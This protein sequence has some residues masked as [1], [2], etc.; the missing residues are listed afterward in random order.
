MN[1]KR[2]LVLLLTAM[3]LF[4]MGACSKSGSGKSDPVMDKAR[5]AWRAAMGSTQPNTTTAMSHIRFTS[6]FELGRA[7][8]IDTARTSFASSGLFASSGHLFGI[9]HDNKPR[10]VIAMDD[11]GDITWIFN[12]QA[13][14]TIKGSDRLS[15]L[16]FTIMAT[17]VCNGV[18]AVYPQST[19]AGDNVWRRLT[20]E[21]I[22]KLVQ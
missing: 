4:T 10:Y 1:L 2:F 19:S 6:V 8:G 18:K 20:Q 5:S 11:E 16:E 14:R 3:L 21:Q 7:L 22:D 17:S 9:M 12:V 13:W 15:S